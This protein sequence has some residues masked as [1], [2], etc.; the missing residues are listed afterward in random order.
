MFHLQCYKSG[1]ATASLIASCLSVARTHHLSCTSPALLLL[2]PHVKEKEKKGICKHIN[3]DR[4][5]YPLERFFLGHCSSKTHFI[6]FLS[7]IV[8]G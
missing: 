2:Y 6:F 5:N 7:C 8:G 4:H 1:D 3:M